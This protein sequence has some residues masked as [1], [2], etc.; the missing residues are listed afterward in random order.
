MMDQELLALVEKIKIKSSKKNYTISV[1]ESCT[2]GLVSWYLTSI[3][4]SSR[5]FVTGIVSYSNEAKINILKVSEHILNQFGA[6]SEETAKSMAIGI[7]NIVNS[8]IALSV[9]GIAGPDGG[10]DKKPIGTVC[11]G[12]CKDKTLTSS[13]SYFSGNREEIRHLACKQ[14]LLLILDNL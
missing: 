11:F 1:A 4:G 3:P 5:Y 8:N 13:T 12:L 7:S 10:S 2:G 9:T 6:V 14:A